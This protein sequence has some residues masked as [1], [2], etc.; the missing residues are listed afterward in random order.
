M[1]DNKYINISET[2]TEYSFYATNNTVAQ[3]RFKIVS[4]P[5]VT[6]NI[7]NKTAGFNIFSFNN[8]IN[9]INHSGA[10]GIVTVYDSTGKLVLEK[11]LSSEPNSIIET[12][13]ETGI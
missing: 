11:Q 7:D 4:H 13:F 10:I 9:I 5:G 12:Q 1:Y 8:K 3:D 6:T 2:G